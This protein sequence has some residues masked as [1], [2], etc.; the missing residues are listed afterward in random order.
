[1]IRVNGRTVSLDGDPGE[2]LA[3]FLRRNG[4]KV[5]AALAGALPFTVLH[6][7][8]WL[9]ACAPGLLA[10]C[11]AACKYLLRLTKCSKQNCR[12]R[13]AKLRVALEAVGPVRCLS[14]PATPK[15]RLPAAARRPHQLLRVLHGPVLHLNVASLAC[16]CHSLASRNTSLSAIVVAGW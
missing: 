2:S 14:L 15:A 6:S 13:A 12:C 4:D 16:A 11:G 1:M 3:E 7:T 10:T 9:R 5:R 8:A